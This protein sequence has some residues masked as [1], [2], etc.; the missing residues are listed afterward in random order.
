MRLS[1]RSS[2]APGRLLFVIDSGIFA[3]DSIFNLWNL[4]QKPQR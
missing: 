2:L 3:M 1:S 4:I